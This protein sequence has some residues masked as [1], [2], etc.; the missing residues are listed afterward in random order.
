[1]AATPFDET[2]IP[3]LE[4]DV[5]SLD[6]AATNLKTK[7]GDL[8]SA[9]ESVKST[10]AG[11][12]VCYKAPEQESLYAAMDPV[13]DDSDTL[14]T[15]IESMA[16]ALS[17]FADTV[18]SLR[19]RAQALRS[20]VLAFK[21][22]VAGDPE[23]DHDQD[24]VNKNNGFIDRA[25]AIQA[26]MWEA[27]RECAN[28]IRDLDGL[29]HYHAESVA[30]SG[31]GSD[32]VYGYESRDLAGV[33][34]LPWGTHVSAAPPNNPA[35]V[36]RRFVWDGLV[37]DGIGGS[38]EAQAS[39]VGVEFNEVDRSVS[40]SLSQMAEAWKGLTALAGLTWEDGGL[41]FRRGTAAETWAEVGK[42]LV[43]WDMWGQDPARA[44]GSVVPDVAVVGAFGAAGAAARGGGA[45]VRGGCWSGQGVAGGAGCCGG[46]AGRGLHGPGGY[47]GQQGG[48]QG[49][50][51]GV[52]PV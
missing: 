8:R 30:G 9:G 5:E 22:E 49:R 20:D 13:A 47:R 21:E 29:E 27:E 36:L 31:A 32:L 33:E 23:W 28:T 42:D 16:S 12:Q 15:S 6:T 39:L 40:W 2:K 1:M 14:A 46:P 4:F 45:A 24:L 26:D 3:C 50:G 7:A 17:T 44:A 41:S 35:E 11:M 18:S 52:D 38:L 43:A 25:S 37:L 51:P 34:E 10:W 48:E 19:T